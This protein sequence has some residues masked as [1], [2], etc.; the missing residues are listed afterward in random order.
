VVSWIPLHDFS[1]GLYTFNKLTFAVNLTVMT[2]QRSTGF[3]KV[4]DIGS[5]V[6][7]AGQN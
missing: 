2:Y 3:E 7:M 4:Q 5:K 1:I 6:G